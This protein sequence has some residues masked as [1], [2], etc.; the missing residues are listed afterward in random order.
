MNLKLVLLIGLICFA[1][2]ATAN[3][4]ECLSKINADDGHVG[5]YAKAKVKVAEKWNTKVNRGR[6]LQLVEDK[7][8]TDLVKSYYALSSETQEAIKK[9]NP[10]S[11]GA[12]ARCN[13]ATN[14]NCEVV[15]PGLASPKCQEGSDIVRLGHS[16]CTTR[17]PKGFADRGLDCYKPKGYKT[18]RYK[19]MEEC[20]KTHKVCERFSLS[21][22]VP[23]CRENFTRQGSDACI[24]TC[25]E[26]W[27]DLGRKCL[28]PVSKIHTE[29]YAWKNSDN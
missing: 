26:N 27:V 19:S 1:S 17:C 5:K 9:C 24:P 11:A 18:L 29:V 4:A 12:L 15:A 22:Y 13:S 6:L 21:Y 7:T 23:V 20:N 2:T 10:S 14:G 28:R 16:I 3:V 8:L 25:P